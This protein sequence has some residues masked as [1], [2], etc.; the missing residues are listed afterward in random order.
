LKFYKCL[1]CV[2][3][4]AIVHELLGGKFCLYHDVVV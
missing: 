1:S 4:H 3:H 2:G